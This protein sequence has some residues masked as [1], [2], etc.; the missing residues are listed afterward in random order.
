M[1]RR[2]RKHFNTYSFQVGSYF[3]QLRIQWKCQRIDAASGKLDSCMYP[4]ARLPTRSIASKQLAG[5]DRRIPLGPI[6]HSSDVLQVSAL[7]DGQDQ[8][9]RNLPGTQAKT[10]CCPCRGRALPGAISE[11]HRLK[12]IFGS[13]LLLQLC[14]VL[15]LKHFLQALRRTKAVQHEGAHGYLRLSEVHTPALYTDL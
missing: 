11:S 1:Y 8:L 10:L 9:T 7:A 2:Q 13:F 5:C 4:S 14:P 12:I 15:G 3:T 6:G